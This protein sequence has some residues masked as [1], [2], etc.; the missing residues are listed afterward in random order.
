M[1]SNFYEKPKNETIKVSLDAE[2]EEYGDFIELKS[3]SDKKFQDHVSRGLGKKKKNWRKNTNGNEDIFDN[4]KEK[5]M[6]CQ[7]IAT[8]IIVDWQMTDMKKDFSERFPNVD[9]DTRAG[10]D[11]KLCNIPFT[12]KNAYELLTHK[13]F[14]SFVLMIFEECGDKAQFEKLEL[15]KDLKN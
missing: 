15:A 13:K 11:K 3:F 10:L 14:D 12:K 4:E 6:Y 1:L 9:V 5:L 2:G 7:A 8:N